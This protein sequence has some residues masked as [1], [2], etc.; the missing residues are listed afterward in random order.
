MIGVGELDLMLKGVETLRLANVC[1]VQ[2]QYDKHIEL[3]VASASA[4]SLV[5]KHRS[6]PMGK[7][8]VRASP[9]EV[10][11]GLAN[12]VRSLLG[13]RLSLKCR[14]GMHSDLGRESRSFDDSETIIR[15]HAD[16]ASRGI[17]I[18]IL[19]NNAGYGLQNPSLGSRYWASFRSAA[20]PFRYSSKPIA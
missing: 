20:T 15:L 13:L 14:Q 7:P 2:Q 5:Q 17:H 3:V 8:A 6:A 19:I 16:L 11:V 9:P 4:E 10:S 18:D 1:S 12:G